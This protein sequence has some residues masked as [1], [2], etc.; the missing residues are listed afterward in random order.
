[1]LGKIDPQIDF[2]QH[3][4]QTRLG[5]AFI[6]LRFEAEQIWGLGEGNKG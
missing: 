6:D 4:E 2:F 5:P 3:I 1:M